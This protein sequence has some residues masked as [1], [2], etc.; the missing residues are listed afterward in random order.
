MTTANTDSAETDAGEKGSLEDAFLGTAAGSEDDVFGFL[1]L[2]PAAPPAAEVVPA[3]RE[4]EREVAVPA[5]A[6]VA[7]AEEPA[8]EDEPASDAPKAERLAYFE[9]IVHREKELYKDTVVAADNRFVEKASPAL[10]AISREKLY[11]EMVSETTGK[12]FTKF[13]DY[14]AERW[15]ISRAHGY[16][17]VNEHPVMKALEPLGA[18]APDKLSA[19]QVPKL[20]AVLRSQGK[21]DEAAGQEAVRTVWTNSEI[22]TPAGL[23][24]TID[25]LGWNDAEA[26]ALDDLSESER[27]RKTLVEKWDLVTS[28][29]DPAKARE[30]LQR[31]P[32]EA[33]RLLAKFKPFVDVLEEVSQ[34]PAGKGKKRS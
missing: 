13:K 4:P 23:Q 17:I 5:A 7:D 27:E 22:K 26:L 8:E 10:Y 16:R 34:L 19:R 21:D 24:E 1:K 33:K 30:L 15:G 18:E 25:K 11:L 6:A 31:D 12:P 28:S 14:L 29:L 3:A 32:A 2:K 9:R 20:L